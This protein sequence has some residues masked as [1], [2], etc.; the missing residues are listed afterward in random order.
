MRKSHATDPDR[1][2]DRRPIPPRVARYAQSQPPDSFARM[3]GETRGLIMTVIRAFARGQRLV[4][5]WNP[6]QSGSRK[7]PGSIQRT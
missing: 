7:S 5:R 4:L 1:I 3:A 6:L 2:D